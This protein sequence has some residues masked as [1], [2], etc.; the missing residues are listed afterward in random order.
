MND[1]ARIAVLESE[2][3]TMKESVSELM[4]DMKS[5]QNRWGLIVGAVV[6]VANIPNLLQFLRHP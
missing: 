1:D 4:S 2:M 6:V 3:K 5:M